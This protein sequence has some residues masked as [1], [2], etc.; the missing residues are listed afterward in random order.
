MNETVKHDLKYLGLKYLEQN[1]DDV[2][3][4]ATKTKMSWHA[5]LQD[6]IKQECSLKRETQRLNRIKNAKIPEM[7]LMET[8]P[9]ARQPKLNQKRIMQMYDSMRYINEQ[10][11]L[12]FIGPTGCGKTGLA[13][14]FLVHAVNNSCRGMFIDFKQLMTKLYQ[15]CA[16]NSTTRL[17]KNLNSIDCMLIDEFG[18]APLQKHHAGLFFDL[19]KARHKN[20]CTIITSQ[21]G[22]EKWPEVINDQHLSAAIMDRI[23]EH[24]V[25]F[26]MNKCVSL[27]KKK[28]IYAAEDM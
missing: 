8:F 13:T 26:N 27:R 24:C 18:Y 5:L 14:S 16:D 17:I 1:W 7:L 9:F 15:S 28:I 19:I 2:M 23:T 6:I 22:F 12:L 20:K 10:L 21:L 11:V 3:A 25:V 4:H